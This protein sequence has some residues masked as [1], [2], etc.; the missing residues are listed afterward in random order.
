MQAGTLRDIALATP[1][2]RFLNAGTG[3]FDLG[4][5]YRQL[6][7]GEVK[8]DLGP[9]EI[10][11]YPEKYQIFLLAALALLAAEAALS[12]WRGKARRSGA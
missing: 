6:I 12:A 9:I 1:G 2:G 3:S 4:G 11:R 8:R 5:I 10:T 7:A